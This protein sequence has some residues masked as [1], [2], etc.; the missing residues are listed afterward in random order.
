[1][2]KAL[3]IIAARGGSK[4]VPG[5]N[6][7]QLGGKPLL[8]YTIDAA[9]EV[10]QDDQIRISTDS[11]EI[12]QEVETL[13]LKVPNLRP[14]Y[15]A[16][17]ESSS[18]DV[19]RYELEEHMRE[20]PEPEVVVQLQ[21]TS[22]FRTADHISKALDKYTK[23][24]DLVVSVK[25]TNAN[26]YFVLFEDNIDGWLERSKKSNF[27]R[28]QD[29]PKVWQFNGAIYIYNTRSLRT[30]EFK[31]LKKIKKFVM[32]E[33]ASHD[34]DTEFDWLIAEIISKKLAQ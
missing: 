16:T 20:H 24:C 12:K 27:L 30:L 13:G 21:V 34:I 26:P 17:D 6:I 14:A 33:W 10:F 11:V 3:C 32:N 9:R 19:L 23:D 7:K 5:K 15:L 28:R 22:P 25:E 4:G 31:D 29:C 18:Y 8:Q 1:M 2:G